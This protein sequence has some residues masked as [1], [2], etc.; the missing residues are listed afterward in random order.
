MLT[1]MATVLASGTAISSAST[2][3]MP[4]SIRV[5]GSRSRISRVTGTCMVMESPSRSV[6]T[7]S[8]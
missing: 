1:G 7:C 3:A 4:V 8:R 5:I 6:A 2:V